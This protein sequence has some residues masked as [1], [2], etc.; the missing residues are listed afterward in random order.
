MVTDHPSK[1][2]TIR[3][4]GV[5]LGHSRLVI[6]STQVD[7]GASHFTEELFMQ[8]PARFYRLIPLT[9]I[10]F[11]SAGS[12]VSSELN[13]YRQ[14][15]SDFEIESEAG[16]KPGFDEWFYEQPAYP[17]EAIPAGARTRAIEQMERAEERRAQLL[18]K[19]HGIAAEAIALNQPKWEALGPRP[20]ANGNT[21]T[22][23]RPAAGRATAIALDPKYDGV[24]NQT[25]YVGAAQGGLWRSRDNGANWEPLIDDQASLA[26]GSV[27][28]D[29]SDSNV[30]YVG[31]GEG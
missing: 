19:Q 8:S 5:P 7:Y 31:T 17:L 1:S 27:A 10:L 4:I 28:V 23:A 21:G 29:P 15:E 24:N 30:I 22:L 13:K 18:R 11:F 6:N 14:I 9:V 20:I 16:E 2:V 25:V 12:F 3:L 26:I